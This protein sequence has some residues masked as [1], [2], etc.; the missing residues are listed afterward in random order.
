MLASIPHRAGK[1]VWQLGDM[2]HDKTVV[3]DICFT[4]DLSSTIT[5]QPSSG[6]LIT[7]PSY[8]LNLPSGLWAGRGSVFIADFSSG[9]LYCVHRRSADSNAA[10]VP[11]SPAPLAPAPSAPSAARVF[12]ASFSRAAFSIG[13]ASTQTR[14]RRRLC[15]APGVGNAG[16]EENRG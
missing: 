12:T 15:R 8:H 13:V 1:R 9:V 2:L 10:R 11:Q 6:V 14:W 16:R 4:P 5:P 7:S 3:R